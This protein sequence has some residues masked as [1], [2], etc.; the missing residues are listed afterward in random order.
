MLLN[1][2][3]SILLYLL[4]TWFFGHILGYAVVK[5][6]AEKFNVFPIALLGFVEG[7]FFG[8]FKVGFLISLFYVYFLY[9]QYINL[10]KVIDTAIS[11]G[12]VDTSAHALIVKPILK[13]GYI[14]RALIMFIITILLSMEIYK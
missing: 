12:D 3:Y 4:F 14:A 9:N 2:A 13:K 6:A 11:N 8:F 5:Y 7:V 10:T 1:I